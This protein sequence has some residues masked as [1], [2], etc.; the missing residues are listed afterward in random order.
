MI[1]LLVVLL[2][3]DLFGQTVSYVLG[4][5]YFPSLSIVLSVQKIC[6]IPLHKNTSVSDSLDVN[7]TEIVWCMFFY[8]VS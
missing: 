7:S 4:N 3:D 5:D 1:L 6:H 8:A 2:I